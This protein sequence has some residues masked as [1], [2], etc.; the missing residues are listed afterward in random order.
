MGTMGSEI[1]GA[2]NKKHSRGNNCLIILS[3]LFF[4]GHD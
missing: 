1:S 4:L 2:R 3:A